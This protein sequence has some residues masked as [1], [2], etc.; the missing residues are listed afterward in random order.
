M[1]GDP[2]QYSLATSALGDDRCA[3]YDRAAGGMSS[4]ESRDQESY[5][6]IVHA[7]TVVLERR[8]T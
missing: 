6:I 3:L 4:S 8:F 2:R 7:C 1:S 5:R